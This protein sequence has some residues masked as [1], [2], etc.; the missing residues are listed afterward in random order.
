MRKIIWSVL[1]LPILIVLSQ[2]AVAK[3]GAGTVIYFKFKSE[4]YLLLAD[5][6]RPQ[7]HDRGWSGF[8]GYCD[9][10][11]F[12]VT[13]ARETEEE[14]KGFYHRDELLGKLGSSPQIR[15]GDFTTF[16]VEVDY[17]P[18][19]MINN[20]KP[21]GHEAAY[22]ERGL[23]AWIPVSAIWQAIAKR[24]TGAVRIPAIYLP[25]DK[26]NNQLFEPFVTSLQAAKTAGILPWEQ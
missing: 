12:D 21:S 5:H 25:P 1:S 23:Y 16:F 11:P 4:I 13:A 17:V 9:G 2:N 7:Q 24:R 10:D 22:L 20:Q 19:I 18:A 14:T 3:C 6:N 8:G 15:V 26:R